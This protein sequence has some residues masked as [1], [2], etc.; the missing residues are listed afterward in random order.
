MKSNQINQ[1]MKFYF[2]LSSN[3]KIY[4]CC[5]DICNGPDLY[6]DSWRSIK[7]FN[8][9]IDLTISIKQQLNWGTYIQVFAETNSNINHLH[10]LSRL[11]QVHL[12]NFIS[13]SMTY[14]LN[15][16]HLMKGNTIGPQIE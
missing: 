16:K 8:E 11:L 13:R 7:L 3:R 2:N 15:N 9:P 10:R 1:L 5:Y 6:D 4:G 14:Q 12:Y